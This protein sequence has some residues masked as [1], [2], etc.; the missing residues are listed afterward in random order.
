MKLPP[1]EYGTI[2]V[3]LSVTSAS[4]VRRFQWGLDQV[5]T[6][7]MQ[8]REIKYLDV[9]TELAGNIEP[10]TGKVWS[11][12]PCRF[13]FFTRYLPVSIYQS[14]NMQRV[15]G[16]ICG[17]TGGYAYMYALNIDI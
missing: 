14:F 17:G 10:V 6:P 4:P 13:L 9:G 7:H 12:N 15:S 3:T 2:F 16:V 1:P 8:Q 11:R 5:G